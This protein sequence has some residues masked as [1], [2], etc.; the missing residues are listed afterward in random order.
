MPDLANYLQTD[1]ERLLREQ[2]VSVLVTQ[3]VE[4]SVATGSVIRTEHAAGSQVE[5]GTTV[6]V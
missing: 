6:I 1:A 3:A 5:A 2:G 4:P